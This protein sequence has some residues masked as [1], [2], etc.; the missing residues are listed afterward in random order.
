LHKSLATVK[1]H[2]SRLVAKLGA[3]NRVRI[4]L[5]VQDAVPMTSSTASVPVVVPV[6]SVA[7]MT[8]TP[9]V[10]PAWLAALSRAPACLETRSYPATPPRG[11][12]EAKTGSRRVSIRGGRDRVSGGHGAGFIRHPDA[13]DEISPDSG[14][15]GQF[16]KVIVELQR[17]DGGWP[18]AVSEDLWAVPVTSGDRPG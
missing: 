11:H 14:T 9:R 18:P 10:G 12:R 6:P 5:P 15:T 13:V 3:E 16:T 8:A 17:D 1:A 2:V 7:P 4:A